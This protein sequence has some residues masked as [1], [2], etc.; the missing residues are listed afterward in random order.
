M[1]SFC[2]CVE[3]VVAGS[4]LTSSLPRGQ[5]HSKMQLP[6]ETC[7]RVSGIEIQQAAF[8]QEPRVR[9]HFWVR[10]V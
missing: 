6:R 10:K 4:H 2:G 1:L 9:M 5:T 7:S 3:N 8:M